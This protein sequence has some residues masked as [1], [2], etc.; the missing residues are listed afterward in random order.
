MIRTSGMRCQNSISRSLEQARIRLTSTSLQP[1]AVRRIRLEV[2][3]GFQDFDCKV[4]F[5]VQASPESVGRKILVGDPTAH[6]EQW[7]N[8]FLSEIEIRFA[9]IRRPLAFDL[10][11]LVLGGKRPEEVGD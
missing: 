6:F 9:P 7:R 4:L 1:F 3:K 2:T 11:I 8:V 5:V 10:K